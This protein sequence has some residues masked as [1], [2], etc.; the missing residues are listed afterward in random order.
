MM[1]DY[2]DGY[3]HGYSCGYDDGYTRGRGEAAEKI[4]QLTAYN[5]EHQSLSMLQ[6]MR[7][8]ALEAENEQ[9]R[10]VLQRWYDEWPGYR[11]PSVEL[12]RQTEKA[13]H[14]DETEALR[15]EGE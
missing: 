6:D 4:E 1:S 9:M 13:L 7:I 8:T 12:L 11:P 2:D 15:G 3:N 5:H 14:V 10:E